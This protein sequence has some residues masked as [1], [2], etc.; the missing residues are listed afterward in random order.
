VPFRFD[1]SEY[2]QKPAPSTDCSAQLRVNLFSQV[3]MSLRPSEGTLSVLER[4]SNLRDKFVLQLYRR[5][6]GAFTITVHLRDKFVLQ[7][8][9]R[10]SG[11]FTITVLRYSATV[12]T[13][14][15]SFQQ[16]QGLTDEYCAPRSRPRYLGAN[17]STGPKTAN[18]PSGPL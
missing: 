2:V 16:T 1:P 7:L 11:A 10:I 14:S 6:S 12:E 9:R 4:N 8:H 15:H 5:I 17:L 3:G 18:S 13:C